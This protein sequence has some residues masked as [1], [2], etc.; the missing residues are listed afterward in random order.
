[1]YIRNGTTTEVTEQG[2]FPFVTKHEWEQNSERA[3]GPVVALA[4]G[5]LPTRARS[6]GS[7]ASVARL[8]SEEKRPLLLWGWRKSPAQKKMGTKRTLDEMVLRKK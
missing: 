2:C 7:N 4:S 1:M 5:S 8:Q 3:G 6:A